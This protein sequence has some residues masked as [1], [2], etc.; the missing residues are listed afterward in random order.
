MRYPTCC[1]RGRG[2]I[3]DPRIHAWVAEPGAF[4]ILVGSSSADI[5]AS[6]PVT[7]R[8]TA[9]AP[10]MVSDMS[11]LQDWLSDAAGRDEALRLLETLAPILG[12]VG[13]VA[14]ENPENLAPHFHSYFGAMPVRDLLEF[15]APA[16]VPEPDARLSTMLE[17][18]SKA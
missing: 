9:A 10:S 14:A 13:G 18:V 16:G 4:E 11:P 5:R 3:C 17:A 6:I 2:E 8:A 1:Y 15:A 7:L 12:G